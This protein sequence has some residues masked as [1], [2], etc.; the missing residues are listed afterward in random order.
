M[1]PNL[2][3]ENQLKPKGSLFYLE[4][5]A[6]AWSAAATMSHSKEIN[7]TSIRQLQITH[8][9]LKLYSNACFEPTEWHLSR[10]II[11]FL[12][13][14]YTSTSSETPFTQRNFGAP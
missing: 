5:G 7:E 14:D 2:S 12:W 11:E 9:E 8:V 1:E 10:L 3:N 4:Y 13:K 6:I